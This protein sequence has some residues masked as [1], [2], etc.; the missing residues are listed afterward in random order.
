MAALGVSQEAG[1][2][3]RAYSRVVT[4]ILFR[5]GYSDRPRTYGSGEGK[6]VGRRILIVNQRLLPLHVNTL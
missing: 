4:L 1:R 2:D 3:T 5:R 6:C